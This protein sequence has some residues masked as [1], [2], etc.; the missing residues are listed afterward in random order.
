M[1][2]WV[3]KVNLTSFSTQNLFQIRACTRKARHL[4]V[5]THC[6]ANTPLGQSERAY[7]ISYF[8][9]LNG[10]Q[11]NQSSAI[12]EIVITTAMI[13]SSFKFVFLQF[14]SSLCLI[15]FLSSVKMNSTNWPALNVWVFIAQL[16]RAL[17]Q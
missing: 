5:T 7:Y 3:N 8:I 10:V 6:H 2:K 14:T 17:Q 12:S 11:F 1:R 16:V 9:R 15:S 13:I 4:V